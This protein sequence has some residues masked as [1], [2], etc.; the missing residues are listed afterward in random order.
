MRNS[1]IETLSTASLL[2]IMEKANTS[3]FIIENL[4]QAFETIVIAHNEEESL[5]ICREKKID[6][7]LTDINLPK[8][9]VVRFIKTLRAHNKS[10]QIAL[11]YSYEDIYKLLKIVEL[12]IS[13]IVVNPLTISDLPIIV[14]TFAQRYIPIQ[15]TYD[16]TAFC[17][18]EPK[19]FLI[20]GPLHTYSLTKKE[21]DFLSMI[22]LNKRIITIEQMKRNIWKDTKINNNVIHSF[23]KNIRKKLPKNTLISVKSIGYKLN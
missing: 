23:I 11:T 18:F 6:F 20:K 10:L 5:K 21:C 22:F 16:I 9:D 17:I 13:K 2:Y 8:M 1:R 19:S 14:E 7:I 3:M 4:K 15:K 12:D